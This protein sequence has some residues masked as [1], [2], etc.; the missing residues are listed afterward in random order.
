MAAMRIKLTSVT[1]DDQAKA[2]AFYRDVLG[3]VVKQ[4]E[5]AGEFRAITLG[6]PEE[7]DGAMLLLEP[8]AHPASRAFQEAMYGDGIPFAIFNVDDLDG[9]YAR[10]SALGVRFT[11]EPTRSEWGYQAMLDDTCG[12]FIILHEG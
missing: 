7:P 10:L 3:F 2:L 5:P 9:E 1:V 6:S 8:N 12:N 4:D 11:Q